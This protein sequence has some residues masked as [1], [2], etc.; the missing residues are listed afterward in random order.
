MTPRHAVLLAA[1][2]LLAASPLLAQEGAPKE[3]KPAGTPYHFGTSEAR[4]TLLFES[5]TSLETIHGVSHRMAGT[6]TLDF[7]GGTGTASF[8]VPVASLRTGLDKRDEHLRGEEWLDAEK[9]PDIAFRAKSLKRTKSD[10]A[11]KR[12]TWE[13]EGSLTIHGVTKDLKGE[14]QVQRIPEDLGKKLGAG[15]WVKVKT[16][17]PVTLKDFDIKVPEIAAAKVSPTWDVKVDIF[18][19][20]QAPK[21]E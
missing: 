15:S 10:E 14:A 21:K 7:E 19:T 4:T 8:T 2:A 5:E 12:E 3:E 17:F 18:G 13:Y 9:F 11:S 1:A 6:A 16:A 20:T